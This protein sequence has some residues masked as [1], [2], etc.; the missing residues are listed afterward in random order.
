VTI[1]TG[2]VGV[3]PSVASEP[4]LRVV[5]PNPFVRAI[6]LR[7]APTRAGHARVT[8]HGPNGRLV[9]TLEDGVFAAGPRDVTWD[10]HDDSGRIVPAGVYFIRAEIDAAVES[11]RIVRVE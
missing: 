3:E 5:G 10:G 11:A 4:G 2:A 8:I 1:H 7:L 9:R 6:A